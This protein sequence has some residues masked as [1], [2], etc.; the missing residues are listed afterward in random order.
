MSKFGKALHKSGE[1]FAMFFW[2]V[3][4]AEVEVGEQRPP[5][6]KY[7]KAIRDVNSALLL[8]LFHV[9]LPQRRESLGEPRERPNRR[10][11]KK[12]HSGYIGSPFIK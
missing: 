9:T 5:R 12:S 7:W 11:H 1:L 3:V 4:R 2:V 6:N 10:I 8:F